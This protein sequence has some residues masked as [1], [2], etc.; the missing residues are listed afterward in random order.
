MNEMWPGKCIYSVSKT[1]TWPCRNPS[2]KNVT[3]ATKFHHIRVDVKYLPMGKVW[4]STALVLWSTTPAQKGKRDRH[5][6]HFATCQWTT[7]PQQLSS[8]SFHGTHGL[9]RQ[10]TTWQ[11]TRKCHLCLPACCIENLQ[12]NWRSICT[13][14]CV[15]LCLWKQGFSKTKDQDVIICRQVAAQARLLDWRCMRVGLI[16]V[17]QQW[18]K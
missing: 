10:N 8:S 4:Q 11:L 7:L 18:Q 9:P 6:T 13:Q 14:S 1:N 2:L 17:R 12:F 15:I 5:V 3:L 16:L